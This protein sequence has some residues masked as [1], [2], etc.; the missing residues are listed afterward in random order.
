MLFRPGELSNELWPSLFAKRHVKPA[1]LSFEDMLAVWRGELEHEYGEAAI[2]STAA[3]A[4]KAIDTT[5]TQQEAL[6]Q[7]ETA[8]ADRD[9]SRF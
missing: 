7:A 6:S 9:K 5:L 1:E 8:W 4:M 3:F 2:I